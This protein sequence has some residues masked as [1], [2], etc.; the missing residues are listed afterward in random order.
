M[1]L[2]VRAPANILTHPQSEVLNSHPVAS[3]PKNNLKAPPL[4][5]AHPSTGHAFLPIPSTSAKLRSSSGITSASGTPIGP[6][7]HNTLPSAASHSIPGL[8]VFT[9]FPPETRGLSESELDPYFVSYESASKDLE[10][11]LQGPMERVNQRMLLHLYKLH[12]DQL[13]LGAKYNA[14]SLS[15]QSQSVAQA[16]E[17]IGQACDSTSIRTKDLSSSLSAQFSEPM[18]EGAQFAGVVRSVL[19][20][21]ILKRVQEEM[22]RDELER[23]K[24]NL[25]ALEQSEQ[26]A[27]RI[28]Q[29]LDN[30]TSPRGRSSHDTAR[31]PTEPQSVRSE[32]DTASVDSDFP[33]TAANAIPSV[34][35]GAP[36]RSTSPNKLMPT[37]PT[38]HKRAPSGS[39]V[40]TKI[41]GRLTHAIHGVVDA[42]PERARRDQIGKTK[43]SLGQLE[44]ALEVSEKDVKDASAGVMQDLERYQGEKEEDLRRYMVCFDSGSRLSVTVR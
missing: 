26:E 39:F 23:K 30:A 41:F 12:E 8:Q 21:R 3:I 40:K 6:S 9:R 32:D 31:T 19:R 35:Q 36:Q 34:D 4:D 11:L 37:S 16:I 17:K 2:C 25:S 1:F 27:K 33:P 42:D 28:Q 43:E 44:Q 29:Y 14:F 13:E 20:Y 38:E 15:E 5:P 22:T 7:D 10:T 24:N 18:R